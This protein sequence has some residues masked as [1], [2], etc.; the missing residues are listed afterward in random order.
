M[1]LNHEN[2]LKIVEDEIGR[3][4]KECAESGEL[5]AASS[6]GKPMNETD[7]Y[8]QTPEELRMAYKVLKDAGFYPPEVELMKDIQKRRDELQSLDGAN[9]AAAVL[10]QEIQNLELN[11]SI[12]LA[13]IRG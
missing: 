11:L 10:L 2:R 9:D 12:L 1:S 5:K 13:K 4:L 6:Y 8:S 7:A 3:H